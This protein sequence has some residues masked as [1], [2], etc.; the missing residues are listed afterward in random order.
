MAV[1]AF[2]L[3]WN[4]CFAMTD[5]E[6]QAYVQGLIPKIVS[7]AKGGGK[8]GVKA[9]ADVI[10]KNADLQYSAK[11]AIGSAWKDMNLEKRKAYFE[12]YK[13]YVLN[14]YAGAFVEIVK[15]STITVQG[16]Q[17]D[18]VTLMVTDKAGKQT[19][20]F[21][22]CRS[23]DGAQILFYDAI[24]EGLSFLQAQRQ[25]FTSMIEKSGV[26]GLVAFLVSH[27]GK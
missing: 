24:V 20:V 8:G 4:C 7:A 16:A 9:V 27:S 1:A 14:K 15:S 3:A 17:G 10:E 11:Y 25:E 5:S 6:L 18:S 23:K 2:V 22:K 12:A 19:K 21:V 13:A 26:D